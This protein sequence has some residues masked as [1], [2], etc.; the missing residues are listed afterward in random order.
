M[1]LANFL[2]DLNESFRKREEEKQR[3]EAFLKQVEQEKK[4]FLREF[5]AI[6]NQELVKKVKKAEKDLKK[7]FKIKYKNPPERFNHETIE[8]NIT[9]Y[10]KFD[11]GVYEAKIV[12]QGHY[13]ARELTITG[14]AVY[15][16]SAQRKASSIVFKD[17]IDRFDP[18]QI[19]NY[20]T[21]VLRHYF[22]EK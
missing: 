5:N 8:G 3:H 7:E 17:K 15:R 9:F 13:K 10:P 21:E 4:D 12:V 20:L 19:E 14:D 2:S 22:I 11:S 16:L 18:S 1:S 6:Y